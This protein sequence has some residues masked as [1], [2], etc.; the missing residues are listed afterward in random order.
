MATRGSTEQFE[1]EKKHE[2]DVIILIQ[3]EELHFCFLL[4]YCKMLLF[5]NIYMIL[6]LLFVQIWN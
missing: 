2:L 5:W 4:M 1:M 3:Q 6:I